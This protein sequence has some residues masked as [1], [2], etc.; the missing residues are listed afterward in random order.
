MPPT[1]M[2]MQLYNHFPLIMILLPMVMSLTMFIAKDERWARYITLAVQYVVAMLSLWLLVALINSPVE[3]Y[4]YALGSFPAP[5]GNELRAGP[6]EAMMSF[7]FAVVMFLS[8]LGAANDTVRDINQNKMRYF[9]LMINL[10]SCSLA[11]MV[12]TN[13]IFTGYVF[14][15]I[16]MLA[17]CSI[18]VAKESGETVKATIK[19]MCLSMVGSMLFLLSVAMLYSISGHLLM[20]PAHE[21][22][23]TLAASGE[24][25]LPLIVTLALFT[26]SVAIKGALFP[27]HTWLPDAHANAT[28][29]VSAILSG[30]VLKGY[31]ILLIKIIYRVYGIEVVD[32]LG[33]MPA[34]FI[35]GMVSMIAG[36]VFALQQKDIKRMVAYSTVAHIGYIFMGI[37]FNTPA[38]FAA[39][40]Y[41]IMAHAFTKSMLFLATGALINAAGSRNISEMLGVAWRNKVAGAA[42][43]VGALSLIG[44]PFFA[45]F[46]SKFYLA[47]AAI[48]DGRGAYIAFIFLAFSTFLNALY[49]VPTLYKFFTNRGIV[50]QEEQEQ[51]HG[52]IAATENGGVITISPGNG[53]L[54]IMMVIN[55]I[56]GVLFLPIMRLLE[57]G[58]KWLS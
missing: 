41:H 12:Y 40:S 55:I 56:L 29:T 27:F 38:G 28:T 5:W 58:F 7:A 9:Y 47:G 4:A 34:M 11:A 6:L 33:V 23:A 19:Y 43:L 18:V 35:L 54:Y 15:E 45:G 39:A 21:V 20:V 22:I 13:D 26:I 31:I 46:P 57:E 52:D 1:Q 24:Y 42:F 3:A 17:A 44:I 50:M 49:Y 37:G 36:S 53:V 25:T 30:L 8:V 10:L 51:G 14:M 2:E 32:M 48:Q 16:N